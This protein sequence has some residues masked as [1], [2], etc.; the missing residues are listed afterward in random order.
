MLPKRTWYDL[1]AAAA[2]L[3]CSR[4]KRFIFKLNNLRLSLYRNIFNGNVTP[5]K[6]FQLL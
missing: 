2:K 3:G 1:D 6:L 4:R 5:K